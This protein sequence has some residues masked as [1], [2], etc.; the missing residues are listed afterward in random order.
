[1]NPIFYTHKNRPVF[2]AVDPKPENN[3]FGR[4]TNFLMAKLNDRWYFAASNGEVIPDKEACFSIY[5]SA[6]KEGTY[7]ET[8]WPSEWKIAD[9]TC[10]AD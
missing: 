8:P 10:A 4:Y 9:F 7:L 5:E 3:I 6:V 1:M 2:T